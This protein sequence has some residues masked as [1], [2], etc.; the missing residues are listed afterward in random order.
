M[1]YHDDSFL[2]VDEISKAIAKMCGNSETTKKIKNGLYERGNFGSSDFPP[3]KEYDHY[4]DTITIDCYGVCDHYQQI[5]D[6]CPILESDKNRE[7]VIFITPV[8]AEDQP[9]DGGWRWCKW[10]EYIG[11]KNPQCQYLY[12]EPEIEM[13][14]VYHI[15]EKIDKERRVQDDEI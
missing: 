2:E 8:C 9:E 14:Y 10:G 1:L 12:D 11:D 4:P 3:S 7:F 13:I 6:K 15:Y 5:L